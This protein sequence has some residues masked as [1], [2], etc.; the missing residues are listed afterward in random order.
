MTM[1]HEHH[2]HEMPGKGWAE[3]ALVAALV[4]ILIVLASQYVW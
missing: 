3:L 1:Q 2:A 4:V